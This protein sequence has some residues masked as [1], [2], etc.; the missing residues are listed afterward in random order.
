MK[1]GS[2][3]VLHCIEELLQNPEDM[4]LQIR[5][6]DAIK[7]AALPQLYGM[8]LPNDDYEDVI[9]RVALNVFKHLGE[10]YLDYVQMGRSE[11]E[12]NKWLWR[13]VRN[14][15]LSYTRKG[16]AEK[17]YQIVSMESVG[18]LD[19]MQ[20]EYGSNDSV[21]K[22]LA[23]VLERVCKINTSVDKT[24]AF[25]LL[26]MRREKKNSKPKELAEELD[27]MCLQD[28]YELVYQEIQEWGLEEIA[29]NALVVLQDKL[30]GHETEI[31]HASPRDLTDKSNWIRTKL[32]NQLI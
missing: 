32:K 12:R 28:V 25:I 8:T 20:A 13:I 3:E 16:K 7:S 24:F 27:G 10:F 9:Q 21:V 2:E 23:D 5:L 11:A 18:E 30:K 4:G 29:A 26:S 6:Y 14:T 17:Q 15:C 31:F 22:K 1:F 19:E